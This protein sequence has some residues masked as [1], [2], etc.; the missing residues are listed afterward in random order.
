MT[1]KLIFGQTPSRKLIKTIEITLGLYN[2]LKNDSLS[3]EIDKYYFDL[4]KKCRDFLSSSGGQRIT[5]SH[6]KS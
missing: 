1:M 3:F 2:A 4:I 6:G 5:P